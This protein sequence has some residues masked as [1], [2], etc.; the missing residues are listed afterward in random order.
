M[1]RTFLRLEGLTTLLIALWL[2]Y[3]SESSW[4]LLAALLLAPDISMIGYLKNK[5]LGALLYNLVHNYVLPII[6][7]A[8]SMLVES[9]LLFSAG[10]ILLAHVGLDRMLGYGLKYNTGFK[11]THMQKV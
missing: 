10:L 5:S 11:D 8:V 2:Y 7:I 6:V 9:N 1:V 3:W 4:I